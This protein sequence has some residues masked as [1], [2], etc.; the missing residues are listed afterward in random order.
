M[1]VETLETWRKNAG[2]QTESCLSLGWQVDAKDHRQQ[3][4]AGC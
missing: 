3:S 4:P 2:P 1:T